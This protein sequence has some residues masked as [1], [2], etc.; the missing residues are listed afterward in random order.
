[1][2]TE[3]LKVLWFSN[4]SVNL[5]NNTLA[6]G[7]MQSLEKHLLTDSSIRLFIATRTNVQ[8]LKKIENS[9]T[10]YY[11]IPEK[12]SLIQKRI[13]LFLNREPIEDYL[14]SNLQVIEEVKPD[15]IQV[16]GTEMDYGLICGVTNVPVIIH[17]QGIL[18]PYLYQLT[19]L[20][21][22]YWEQLKVHSLIDYIKGNT[23][24]DG[25]KIFQRRTKVEQQILNS[26]RYLIGRTHWDK[27]VAGILAP[28]AEYFHCDELLRDIF[29]QGQ[30]LGNKTATIQI[31]STISNPLYKGHDT[32]IATCQVLH[33][34]GI[35]FI[36]HVI[37]IN[38]HNSSYA[39][40]YK[41]QTT[42]FAHRLQLHGQLTPAQILEQLQNADVYVHPSHIENSSN[43]LC[44][45]M[46]VGMPVIALNVGGNDSMIQQEIDGVLVP[47]NDPYVLAAAIYEIKQNPERAVRL[48]NQAKQTASRRHNPVAVVSQ[49][50]QIYNDLIERHAP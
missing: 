28:Q 13:D 42:E 39:L 38:E 46:A 40:F 34:A 27:R 11:L 29:F 41:S 7:W 23:L 50:K 2:Q 49:L 35:D 3:K 37:G 36:W 5:S 16:F 32:L 43:S 19:K 48:A 8:S 12:R 20:P 33:A 45:A 17:I 31:V 47:D 44:E 4:N 25:L 6:G 22:P 21:I 30:W 15:V 10:T 9:A 24:N 14:Q 26:C 1:M 18:H